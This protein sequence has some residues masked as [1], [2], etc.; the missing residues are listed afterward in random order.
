MTVGRPDDKQWWRNFLDGRDVEVWLL[1]RRHP[2]RGRVERDGSTT[3][4]RVVL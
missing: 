3:R 4:V 2:G 1:G